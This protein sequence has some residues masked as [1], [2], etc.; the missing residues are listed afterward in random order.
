MG[1]YSKQKFILGRKVDK[2]IANSEFTLK[3]PLDNFVKLQECIDEK[4]AAHSY[5][6]NAISV[7]SQ[8]ALHS[9][10]GIEWRTFYHWTNAHPDT[11]TPATKLALSIDLRTL[12][13]EYRPKRGNYGVLINIKGKSKPTNEKQSSDISVQGKFAANRDMYGNPYAYYFTYNHQK[14]FDISNF[15]SISS[16]DLQFYQDETFVDEFGDKVPVIL[17]SGKLGEADYRNG[18]DNIFI[19]G[20]EVFLG[21]E[22]DEI[23]KEKVICY[24]YD[25]IIY[26][27]DPLS[28]VDRNNADK[29]TLQVAWVH[30]LDTDKYTVIDK[31]D[32]EGLSKYEGYHIYWYRQNWEEVDEQ[33]QEVPDNL[34]GR[35]WQYL[36]GYDD[37][38]TIEVVND[39]SRNKEQY[40]AIVYSPDTKEISNVLEFK[41]QIDIDNTNNLLKS[42]DALCF[43]IFKTANDGKELIQDD[44]LFNF[45]CY[46]EL[47]KC[48][49]TNDGGLWSNYWYYIQV[50]IKDPETLEYKPLRLDDKQNIVVTWKSPLD[51]AKTDGTEKTNKAKKTNMVT[52]LYGGGTMFQDFAKLT[53][54]EDGMYLKDLNADTIVDANAF[55]RKFK[56]KPEYNYRYNNNLIIASFT[57]NGINYSLSRQ[58]NFGNAASMGSKYSVEVLMDNPLGYAV[59]GKDC[60]LHVVIRNEEGKDVTRE[61]VSNIS[62]TV[63]PNT[64]N[65]EKDGGVILLTNTDQWKMRPPI[66]KCKVINVA[67]YPLEVVK[68]INVKNNKINVTDPITQKN[69]YLTSIV[70]DRI[71]Y[72]SD[73]TIPRY[74][75]GDFIIQQSES[76][77]TIGDHELQMISGYEKITYDISHFI[78]ENEKWTEDE[79]N[80]QSILS[81]IKSSSSQEIE[82]KKES[83]KAII[84]QTEKGK[85]SYNIPRYRL[86]LKNLTAENNSEWYWEDKLQENNI[87]RINTYYDK[88]LLYSQSVA[89]DRNL[90]SS[91]LVNSWN[92]DELSLDE[93]NNA[94][95]AKMIGAGTKDAY[96]RF[97][98]ILMGD[99][100]DKSDGSIRTGITG[101]RNGSQSF[102]FKTDGTG[103]IGEAGAGQITFDGNRAKIS[104]S[105]GNFYINLNPT[106]AIQSIA[107]NGQ[108]YL[109]ASNYKSSDQFFLYSKIAKSSTKKN[110]TATTM[111]DSGWYTKFVEDVNN[112]YFIVDPANGMFLSGGIIA[113]YG[114]LGNWTINEQGMYQ[115]NKEANKYMFL[116]YNPSASDSSQTDND[117]YAIFAGEN[118]YANPV[119]SV[120]WSGVLRARKGGFGSYHTGTKD[121]EYSVWEISDEGLTNYGK[122]GIIHLGSGLIN[123][124]CESGDTDVVKAAEYYNNPDIKKQFFYT[125]VVKDGT[126]SPIGNIKDKT[127]SEYQIFAADINNQINFGVSFNG[128]LLS[129]LGIIGGWN[130]TNDTLQAGNIILNSTENIF[131]IG[132]NRAIQIKGD[133][134]E[135]IINTLKD[136]FTQGS[137]QLGS[138]ILKGQSQ[139]KITSSYTTDPGE[140]TTSAS[141]D[142][143]DS[144]DAAYNHIAFTKIS[145]ECMKI[146]SRTKNTITLTSNSSLTFLNGDTG[147]C[148]VS[149]K[150]QVTMKEFQ[151]TKDELVD[152]TKTPIPKEENVT[153]FYPNQSGDFNYL[154]TTN[155]RWNV[156]GKYINAHA[157]ET[158]TLSVL[159]DSI[160]MHGEKVATEKW[161]Y[162]CL[163]D[164][165][166]SIKGVS[167]TAAEAVTKASKGVSSL[168]TALANLLNGVAVVSGVQIGKP[169]G[170][171]SIGV[172]YDGLVF[173]V[174]NNN[175]DGAA[176]L[177]SDRGASQWLCTTNIVEEVKVTGNQGKFTVIVNGVPSDPFDITQL[178]W[179]KDQILAAK[180]EGWDQAANTVKCENDGSVWGPISGSYGKFKSL[181]TYNLEKHKDSDLERH[182]DP[183]YSGTLYS[184]NGKTKRYINKGT[185]DW[186]LD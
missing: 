146:T 126:V 67:P 136:N 132:P 86:S 9:E 31:D 101:F 5:A 141:G 85:F 150:G 58:F 133:T 75:T 15:L 169:S 65:C 23:G 128:K 64:Y 167:G 74:S 140:A 134:G 40:C 98:G 164:V 17:P 168:S 113:T 178:Q 156:L 144:S 66:I 90:Y 47:N 154:G 39:I 106:R 13:G 185:G 18:V 6:A 89:F 87:Y 97:T 102:G 149:G 183:K 55:T 92:S 165:Y 52:D 88:Q 71:E 70:P 99:F 45:Y 147:I 160:Y 114:K 120:S 1:D 142:Q 63:Y 57:R 158:N 170:N 81:I 171:N 32:N 152:T 138:Y 50:Y 116:G 79:E 53:E 161:V 148:L 123:S 131:T 20:V 100:T 182:N 34:R 153:I 143:E 44:T 186:Y 33:L 78:Y 77:D 26:G 14:V 3:Q 2:E 129:R 69:Y 180:K 62:W 11:P 109:D 48:T 157:I 130:I 155:N 84:I 105:D 127:T 137:I 173:S 43:R 121:K 12:L 103:F 22:A 119:F 159:N 83:D 42:D 56:I 16:I 112:D 125:K 104:S 46:D 51:V 38:F 7:E 166:N 25:D 61:N 36:K 117:T 82:E 95:L 184:Y 28:T 72:K 94:I 172:K 139:V 59:S 54:A 68:G 115:K 175:K 4:F 19:D 179:Y 135:I 29:R 118:E 110:T 80:K 163:N 49:F 73:G 122:N 91:S 21:L 162:D 176:G 93:K 41:N 124:V 24:T 111:N 27:K 174:T 30:Q 76:E 177:H 8:S 145:L 37:K 151:V 107:D 60:Q 10:A 96:N 181:H 108:E 35:N